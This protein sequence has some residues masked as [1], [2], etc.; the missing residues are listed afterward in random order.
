LKKKQSA[1]TK[2]QRRRTL[3]KKYGVSRSWLLSKKGSKL[4][5]QLTDYLK[6]I[7]PQYTILSDFP[8]GRYKIDILF[9]ELNLVV[10]FNGTYWHCDPRFYEKN[11][12][13]QKK[14]LN[15]EQI[16]SY[17]NDRKIFLEGLGYKVIVVWEHDYKT[18]SEQTLNI[19]S[20]FINAKKD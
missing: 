15:A 4:Q 10:E 11:Y 6:S 12:F 18:N 16:W 5:T 14:K 8:I 13:N 19:L 1:K 2:S 20:E 3:L 9:K 7:F 17:D